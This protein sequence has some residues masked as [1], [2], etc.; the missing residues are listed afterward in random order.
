MDF[1]FRQFWMDD[2]LQFKAR[3]GLDSL[4]VGAE[5]TEKL[6]LPDTFFA[7]EKSAYFHTATTSNSFLRITPT[8][9][10]LRSISYFSHVKENLLLRMRW[11][12]LYGGEDRYAVVK[13][14]T[15]AFNLDLAI[16][17]LTFIKSA[18]YKKNV[19]AHI[20]GDRPGLIALEMN[21]K[22]GLETRFFITFGFE[23][24]ESN[25]HLI[26]LYTPQQVS[27]TLH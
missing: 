17:S 16:N 20:K 24:Y 1:Y 12:L 27:R 3:P 19:C 22:M 2:R 7:N 26:T 13:V 6:W 9:D 23:F 25:H 10:V 18:Y 5:M 15:I 8:G 11:N 4:S 21:L 14:E